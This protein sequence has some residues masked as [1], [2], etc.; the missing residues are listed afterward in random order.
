MSLD[1]TTNDIAKDVQALVDIWQSRGELNA[2]HKISYVWPIR[3]NL[4]DNWELL[5]DALGTISK[6]PELPEDE[7]RTAYRLYAE[8]DAMLRNR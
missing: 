4:T 2:L 8:V 6:Y 1:R 7:R 5:Q 3:L